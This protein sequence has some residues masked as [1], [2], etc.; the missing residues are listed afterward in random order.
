[1]LRASDSSY[2]TTSTVDA[3]GGSGILCPERAR[4]YA[5]RVVFSR[6][7]TIVFSCMLLLSL[8]LLVW[9]LVEAGY[10]LDDAVKFWVFVALDSTVTLFLLCEILLALAVSGCARFWWH[11]AHW[12]DVA[13]FVLCVATI[14][15]HVLGPLSALEPGWTRQEEEE[16]VEA[17]VLAVRYSTQI[18][19]LML[20]LKHFQRQSR[21]RELTEIHLEEEG[22]SQ[23]EAEGFAEVMAAR[24]RGGEREAE[25]EPSPLYAAGTPLFTAGAA[26]SHEEWR[27]GPCDSPTSP[28]GAAQH[29]DCMHTPPSPPIPP[30]P[31]V[32]DDRPAASA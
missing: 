13:V 10:P 6:A 17:G 20:M 18:L 8:A 11:W 12:V 7:Y 23:A 9:V 29:A 1:M 24:G 14:A 28:A 21:T 16:E 30:L 26:R 3:G 4:I 25:G 5:N 2:I 22:V 31:P 27:G 32:E 15:M 19:R